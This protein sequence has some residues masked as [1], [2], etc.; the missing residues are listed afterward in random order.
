LLFI[1]ILDDTG[2]KWCTPIASVATTD[3]LIKTPWLIYIALKR[4]FNI[5]GMW[6]RLARAAARNSIGS[7]ELCRVCFVLFFSL[8]TRQK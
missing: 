6:M 4:I 1:I 2:E 5:F 3:I 8:Y 7:S